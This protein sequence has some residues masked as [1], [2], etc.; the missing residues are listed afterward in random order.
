MMFCRLE[1]NVGWVPDTGHILRGGQEIGDTLAAHQ[2]RVRYVHL[3]DVDAAG[4]LGHAGRGR[5]RR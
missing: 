3:K 2:D 4:K 1:P 5:L